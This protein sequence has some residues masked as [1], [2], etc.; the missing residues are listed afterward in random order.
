[1]RDDVIEIGAI[2]ADDNGEIVGEFNEFGRP[3]EKNWSQGAERVHKI[4]LPQAMRFQPQQKMVEKFS[5]FLAPY[6]GTNIVV[7]HSLRVF[8]WLMIECTFMKA[9]CL[10]D[11]RRFTQT[12]KDVRSTLLIAKDKIQLQ[13]YKLGAVSKALNVKLENAHRAIEDAKACQQIYQKLKTI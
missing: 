11:W 9:D 10:Y 2:I 1:M 8:D 13:S 5:D 3:L 7:E 12:P 4:T 6:A